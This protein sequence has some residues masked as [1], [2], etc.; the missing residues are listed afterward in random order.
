MDHRSELARLV[1][2]YRPDNVRPPWLRDLGIVLLVGPSGAGKGAVKAALI[3]TGRYHELVSHTTRPPRLNQ[4]IQER[5]GVE[6]HFVTFEE[7]YQLAR[8]GKL[9]QFKPYGHH[10]YGT[11]WAELQK[12]A[13]EKRV[14]VTDVNLHGAK[15][16][17]GLG[18]SGLVVVFLIP[19]RFAELLRRM[20]NRYGDKSSGSMFEINKRLEIA[21]IEMKEMLA[22]GRNLHIVVNNVVTATASIIDKAVE[23]R[24]PV[25]SSPDSM[26]TLYQLIADIELY[27]SSRHGLA[28]EP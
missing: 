3:Q 8:S 27:L 5:Q 13:T 26:A 12:A 6:Y 25:E 21:V 22:G 18:L 20:T 16:F 14:A 24:K 1:E 15:E 7:I 17:T 23:S 4:G 28:V 9:V 10:Y 2:C 11:A 19:P